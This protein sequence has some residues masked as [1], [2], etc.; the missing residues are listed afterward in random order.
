MKSLVWRREINPTQNLNQHLHLR[1]GG[2][3]LEI[4][5]SAGDQSTE[6]PR[7]AGAAE[8]QLPLGAALPTLIQVLHSLNHQTKDSISW[9]RISPFEMRIHDGSI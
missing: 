1:I 9:L 5:G 2:A 6:E 7:D 4:S 8:A 3:R